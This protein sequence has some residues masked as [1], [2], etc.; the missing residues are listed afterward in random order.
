MHEMDFFV[1]CYLFAMLS[2]IKYSLLCEWVVWWV[3]RFFKKHISI[4]GSPHGDDGNGMVLLR[5]ESIAQHEDRES[6]I[7]NSE[8]NDA[9]RSSGHHDRGLENNL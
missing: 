6:L 7:S 3:V 2:D 9:V 5:E 4:T 1:E 8:V